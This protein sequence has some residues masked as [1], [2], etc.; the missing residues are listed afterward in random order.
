VRLTIRSYWIST[1]LAYDT[2]ILDLHKAEKELRQVRKRA[3]IYSLNPAGKGDYYDTA[4]EQFRREQMAIYESQKKRGKITEYD[5]DGDAIGKRPMTDDEA[6]QA[7][8]AIATRM[9][10]KYGRLK[11]GTQEPTAKGRRGAKQKLKTGDAWAKRQKYELELSKRRKSGKH[12]VVPQR[13]GKQTRYYVQPGGRYFYGTG[14]KK[15]AEA[16]RDELNGV[17]MRGRKRKAANPGAYYDPSAKDRSP[18]YRMREGYPDLEAP[19]LVMG[20]GGKA[21]EEVFE[22]KK[23]PGGAGLRRSTSGRTGIWSSS[24]GITGFHWLWE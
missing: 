24:I 23:E 2:L 14:A 18:G 10:Q 4:R 7:S 22:F 15:R 11:P 19:Y 13:Q 16:L 20:Y 5:S 12:R 9:G 21:T 17:K 1:R 6:W 8:F 3:G